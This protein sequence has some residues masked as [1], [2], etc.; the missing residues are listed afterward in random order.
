MF[1]VTTVTKKLRRVAEMSASVL[2]ESVM[3]NRPEAMALTFANYVFPELWGKTADEIAGH[4]AIGPLLEYVRGVEDAAGCEV[5]WVT[6][7]PGPEHVIDV[8]TVQYE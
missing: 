4:G 8:R 3:L 1:E 7:G 6:V 5:R 2:K